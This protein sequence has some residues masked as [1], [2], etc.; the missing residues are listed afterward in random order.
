M[1]A[2]AVIQRQK[3]E[4]PIQSVHS[5]INRESEDDLIPHRMQYEIQKLTHSLQKQIEQIED[6]QKKRLNIL[7]NEIRLLIKKLK[8][9]IKSKKTWWKR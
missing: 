6:M 2:V 1:A 3:Q 8:K 7:Q 4:S 9:F 5:L